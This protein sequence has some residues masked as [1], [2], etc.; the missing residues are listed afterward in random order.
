[1]AKLLENVFRNVNIALV[2][3]LALLSE[4]MGLDVWEV[5]D[6]A[7]T[8][9]FGFMPFHPGRAWVATASRSI[10]TTSPGARANLAC[11]IASSS[12]P[13]TSTPRCPSTWLILWATL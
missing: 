10:R 6:A 5:I 11:P 7:A 1:M 12:W 2:N 9:P 13:A 8:K 4:R 3:Q